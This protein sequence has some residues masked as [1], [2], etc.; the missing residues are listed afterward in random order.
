MRQEKRKAQRKW[1]LTKL[2]IHHQIYLHLRNKLNMYIFKA[3]ND[4]T[5]QKTKNTPNNQKAL[6]A[7][8]DELLYRSKSNVLPDHQSKADLADEFASFFT[9]KVCK[10]QK[11]LNQLSSAAVN[12]SQCEHAHLSTLKPATVEE[13]TKIISTSP[14][15]SCCL[16]PI[17]TFLL[18]QC[19]VEL[20]PV[21]TGIINKS[22]ASSCVPSSFK[23]AV[24]TPLLKKPTLDHDQ[25]KNY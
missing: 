25:M 17:P 3:K 10:I 24:V 18:K 2:T 6:F 7:A 14:N 11:E 19:I 12:D 1:R 22:M 8:L 13:I 15:K 20:A 5:Q 23:Q 4:F 21:I 9:E 16:D